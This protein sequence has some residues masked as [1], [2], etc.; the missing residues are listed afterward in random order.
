MW[1]RSAASAY[2]ELRRE[3]E[4]LFDRCDNMACVLSINVVQMTAC[5]FQTRSAGLTRNDAADVNPCFV[6][7]LHG[8]EM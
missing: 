7:C 3:I 2:S 5:G 1:R 8:M 4:A 6:Y